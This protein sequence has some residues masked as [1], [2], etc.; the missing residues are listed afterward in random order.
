MGQN[1]VLCFPFLNYNHMFRIFWPCKTGQKDF[2]KR[3][4]KKTSRFPLHNLPQIMWPLILVINL[5]NLQL[6]FTLSNAAVTT[7]FHT[8]LAPLKMIF[9]RKV[10]NNWITGLKH[11][12]GFIRFLWTKLLSK[13]IVP[14]YKT[15]CRAQDWFQS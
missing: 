6:F 13:I 2:T 10:P 3:L 8:S 11:L 7:I 4:H 15:T 14:I 9:L 5:N 1:Q 12:R